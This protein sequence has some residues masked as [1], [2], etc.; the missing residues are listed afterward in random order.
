MLWPLD[1]L[2]HL[3]FLVLPPF[4]LFSAPFSYSY[5]YWRPGM[6]HPSSAV[7]AAHLQCV[8]FRRIFNCLRST[9]SFILQ[10]K[11]FSVFQAIGM[12]TYW[13]YTD[14]IISVEWNDFFIDL[15]GDLVVH[16]I[17][18]SNKCWMNDRN[19]L[20]VNNWSGI[21]WIV[22][23]EHFNRLHWWISI[24]NKKIFDLC[25]SHCTM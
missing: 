21:D 6:L 14:S 24:N 22:S 19:E 5:N 25:S 17:S 2:A 13:I 1:T 9:L 8:S 3:Y 4:S 11:L 7:N 20:Y 12:Y 18:Y 16:S 23:F 15:F 10:L